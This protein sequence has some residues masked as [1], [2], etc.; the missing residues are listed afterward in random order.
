MLILIIL[1]LVIC[2]IKA[3][4][5][6]K[7]EKNT[8]L[9]R[10]V[11][12]AI[13]GLFAGFV[14]CSHFFSYLDLNQINGFDNIGVV[15]TSV[16]GQ[17]MVAPFLFYSGYGVIESFKKKGALYAKSYPKRRILKLYIVFLNA[18]LLFILI[19]L[20]FNKPYS[21]EQYILSIFT[22]ASIGNSNWYVC[23]I[24][25]LYF[26]SYLSF[27]LF[28][29]FNQKGVL[30]FHIVAGF[31]TVFI[32][33]KIASGPFWW[34]TIIAYV[35]GVAFSC[36]KERIISFITAKKYRSYMMLGISAF[37]FF[38][39][40]YLLP[41]LLGENNFFYAGAV[42]FFVLMI[43]FLTSVVQIKNVILLTLGKNSFWIYILQRVP[44]ILF[45]EATPIYANRY[46]YLAMCLLGTAA[47]IAYLNCMKK[48]TKGFFVKLK[49]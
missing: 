35:V 8:F 13:S 2:F 27:V 34:N 39:F 23:V 46:L 16:M 44:M 22:F 30:V 32:L 18:L 20:I 29:T 14:F 4:P 1:L 49:F 11:T 37:L 3:R 36:Y 19:A 28:G 15:F 41:T 47:I 10:D 40:F 26:V 5:Q 38:V 17:L 9:D 43:V 6:V 7:N 21:A 31:A 12:L 48:A 45:R 24:L 25:I 33:Q 42:T